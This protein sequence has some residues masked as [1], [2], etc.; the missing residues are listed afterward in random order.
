MCGA[1]PPLLQYALM[2]WCS[3]KAQGQLYLLPY[4]QGAIT[5]AIQNRGPSKVK[6]DKQHKI[7]VKVKL[8]LRL[9]KPHALKTH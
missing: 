3:V 6:K 2:V 7:A 5:L 9:T 4:H 1:I 8:P